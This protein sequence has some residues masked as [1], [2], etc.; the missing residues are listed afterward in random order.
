MQNEKKAFLKKIEIKNFNLKFCQQKR[1]RKFYIQLAPKLHA[2]LDPV[3]IHVTVTA[4]PIW[5]AHLFRGNFWKKKH[6]P[7]RF[8][9]QT[10]LATLN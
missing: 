9:T 6:F 1:W 10:V 2:K 4:G 7:K 8:Y 3:I 5:I